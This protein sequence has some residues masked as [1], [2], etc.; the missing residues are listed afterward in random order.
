MPEALIACAAAYDPFCGRKGMLQD[1]VVLS[2]EI[3]DERG[4]SD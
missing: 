3:E 4:Q 2:A 1:Q